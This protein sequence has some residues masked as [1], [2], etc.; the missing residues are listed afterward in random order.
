M[1]YLAGIKRYLLLTWH[2]K[3]D[4]NPDEGTDLLILEAPEPWG[5]FSLVHFEELWEG[6]DFTPYCP[7]IPLKWMNPDHTSGY[8]QFSGSWEINKRNKGYYRSNIRQ[9]EISF[10]EK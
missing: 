8:I 9:F 5:P 1:V 2:F 3:E 6:K 7:R 4:F 10:N